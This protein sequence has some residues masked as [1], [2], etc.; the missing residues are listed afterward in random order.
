MHYTYNP[1]PRSRT[2]RAELQQVIRRHLG[3]SSDGATST[4]RVLA[5]AS[6]MAELVYL[7]TDGRLR[8]ELRDVNSDSRIDWLT[9]TGAAS[10]DPDA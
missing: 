4:R 5:A 1:R 9:A 8:L 10:T 6:K 2:S 3:T 7:A